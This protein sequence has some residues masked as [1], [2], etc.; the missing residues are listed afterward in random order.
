MV[1]PSQMLKKSARVPL[2]FSFYS[3]ESNFILLSPIAYIKT[4]N[5]SLLCKAEQNVFHFVHR[6]FSRIFFNSLFFILFFAEST[7]S[8]KSILYSLSYSFA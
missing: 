8:F 2:T 5:L 3:M 7:N 1:A 4:V 6:N